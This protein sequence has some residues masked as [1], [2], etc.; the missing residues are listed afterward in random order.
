MTSGP[1]ELARQGTGC[2]IC[3]RNATF[4]SAKYGFEFGSAP[5]DLCV[6]RS[7]IDCQSSW[8]VPQ[9]FE[10]VFGSRNEPS[11]LGLTGVAA[12]LHCTRPTG[13][14]VGLFLAL[15][16]ACAGSYGFLRTSPNEATRPDTATFRSLLAIC[17]SGPSRRKGPKSAKVVS[18]TQINQRLTRGRIK[19]LIFGMGR[20][21]KPGPIQRVLAER[22][23]PLEAP[24]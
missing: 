7:L 22:L 15:P 21:R 10:A 2:W 12:P 8:R 20:G 4:S 6:H 19:R 3:R 11:S 16:R 9:M 1:S 14:P 23:L 24:L 13:S 17:L 18:H 5:F